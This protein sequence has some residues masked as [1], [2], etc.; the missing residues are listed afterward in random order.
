MIADQAGKDRAVLRFTHS[1][2]DT[3]SA[4]AAPHHDATFSQKLDPSQQ[5]EQFDHSQT[6]LIKGIAD[7]AENHVAL[8]RN[9]SWRRQFGL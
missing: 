3:A 7:S 5:S 8:R 9:Y 1:S 6:L 2:R 4:P